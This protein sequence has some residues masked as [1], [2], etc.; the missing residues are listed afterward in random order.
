M[1]RRSSPARLG[2][3]LGSVV[4]HD[5]RQDRQSCPVVVQERAEAGVAAA[6]EAAITAYLRTLTDSDLA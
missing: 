3:S 1:L 5:A 2:L 6:V 4:Q